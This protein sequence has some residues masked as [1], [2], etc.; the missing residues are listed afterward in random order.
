M[1]LLSLL[2]KEI[3]H[4]F[5]SIWKW[6]KR[7]KQE[8]KPVSGSNKKRL[9]LLSVVGVSLLGILSIVVFVLLTYF[10]AF[11]KIPTEADLRNIY[12]FNASEVYFEDEVLLGKYFIENRSDV[13][14]GEISPHVVNALIATEDARFM[15]HSGVDLRA[16]A[17]V[18]WKSILL[19]QES[20]GGGSTISQQLAKNLYPRQNYGALGMPINKLKEM[21]TAR[22]LEQVYSKEGLLNLYLNT[23]P[24]SRNIYGI[25]IASNQ[26]Y[27]TTPESLKAEQAA[28]LVGM[29]KGTSLYDPISHPDRSTQRR[30]VVL[31]QMERYGYLDKSEVDSLV[32]LPLA[33]DYNKAQ[34]RS[35][36]PYFQE[37]LKGELEEILSNIRKPTGEP[38][39]LYTDGLRVYTT[40]DSKMQEY[41]EYAVGKH[42]A[43]LQ[44]T[45]NKHWKGRKPWRSDG[46]LKREIQKSRRY[47]IWKANGYSDAKIDSLFALPVQMSI[48]DWK[49]GEAV[50]EMSPLDSVKYY[51]A[52][53]HAGFLAAE[54]QS[55]K[56]R[57]WV[58]GIDYAH[59]QYD[60]VKS[61]RQVGSTFKPIV[62]T[63]AVEKG[64]SPCNYFQN[65]LTTYPDWED[66]QPRN[67][68]GKYGGF[69]S[70]AGGLS[71]SVNTITVEILFQTGIENVR[72]LA[73]NMGIESSIP[74][75]PAIALGAMEGSL[76]EM[77]QVYST[78]ANRGEKVNLHTI[79]RIET[80]NGT[81]IYEHQKEEKPE[82]VIRP[83]HVD[84]M[85]HL[86]Q[87]VVD[88]GTARRLRYRHG[89]YGEIAGKTG[90]TQNQSD[91]WFIGYKSN[92][93]AGAWVGAENPSV[94][95]RSLSLGQGANTALPIWGHFMQKVY[96]D[97]S[98]K[99]IRYAKFQKPDEFT[100]A[101]IECD[102][103]IPDEIIDFDLLMEEERNR[104]FQDLFRRNDQA[105][106][107]EDYENGI[108]PDQMETFEQRTERLKKKEER[109][110]KLKD[111]WNNKL[112]GK[113][114]KK[115][116]EERENRGG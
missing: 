81:I 88:S 95:F 50:K 38:Y 13:N 44:K 107:L 43:S 1:R 26:F 9:I 41:A 36:A 37:H 76:Y 62:Y 52:L 90:T 108:P 85:T 93:V 71:K 39:G 106:N 33:L 104:P 110:R 21:M 112:F 63:K 98:F 105:F 18:L 103:Y 22:R 75:G 57:A 77:I 56:I 97:K 94:H 114:E 64:I 45:F 92:L 23:V 46:I 58:G 100:L 5:R 61:K 101:Q 2:Q 35:K 116:E 27:S 54:P 109:K 78:L 73:K 59:F 68:D 11:G 6:V 70:M 47:K 7:P 17:R 82:Q 80:S 53:L 34:K 30:N 14:I 83:E 60:H 102:P 10:G 91:G 4:H 31:R 87:S 84:I 29:L 72:S 12:N 89:L 49:E 28:V 20:S 86:L 3:N 40:I 51:I 99:S 113:K 79:E 42:M 65:M 48:F 16:A 69:Y 74:E 55:G 96:K 8:G 15:E 115:K 66:W 25:K 111:L 24:F 32:E 19:G 67:S